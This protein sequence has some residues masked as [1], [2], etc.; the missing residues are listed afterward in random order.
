MA[1]P[2]QGEV[3]LV[4]FTE[5]WERPAV[6][7]SRDE[8]NRGTLILVVPCTSQEAELRAAFPNHVPLPSGRGGLAKDSVAQA[9]LVQ[10]AHISWFLNRLGA[11]DDDT[12]CEV[13]AAVAWVIDFPGPA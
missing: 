1:H 3:W 7:V 5:G 12:L 6:V 11:V 4:N 8:L 2:R 10:P 9:Q 13:L